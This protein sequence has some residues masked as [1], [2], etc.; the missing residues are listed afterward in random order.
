MYLGAT[1]G[2]IYDNLSTKNKILNAENQ[3]TCFARV[4]GFYVFGEW[5]LSVGVG[6]M[7][8]KSHPCKNKLE[9]P[10]LYL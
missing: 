1:S 10:L 6:L 7:Y 3:D 4:V 5:G 2:S 9:K 8:E